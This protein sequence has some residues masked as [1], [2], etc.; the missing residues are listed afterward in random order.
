M[1]YK[2]IPRRVKHVNRNGLVYRQVLDLAQCSKLF[3][4]VKNIIVRAYNKNTRK[5]L[6][7]TRRPFRRMRTSFLNC[8]DSERSEIVSSRY[9][10]RRVFRL[11]WQFA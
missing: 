6:F 4:N 3:K 2:K 5:I 11:S 9:F 10:S 8:N 7:S 1:F